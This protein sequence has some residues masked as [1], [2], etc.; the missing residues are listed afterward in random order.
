ML[1][2]QG[3][4]DE[5][6]NSPK[7]LT[8]HLLHASTGNY[9]NR[10]AITDYKSEVI[11]H[12]YN[13]LKE[14]AFRFQIAIDPLRFYRDAQLETPLSLTTGYLSASFQKF[15]T[16]ARSPERYKK[17]LQE[18]RLRS[19]QPCTSSQLGGCVQPTSMWSESLAF[20][21]SLVGDSPICHI[22]VDA[23][24]PVV[25]LRED[26]DLCRH[27]RFLAQLVIA[28]G[29][30]DR[31]D[32]SKS[33]GTGEEHVHFASAHDNLVRYEI[34]AN[35][36][37]LSPT[38]ETKSYIVFSGTCEENDQ[39]DQN[40]LGWE[41]TPQIAL[42]QADNTFQ[43]LAHNRCAWRNISP[44]PLCEWK[45]K[46]RKGK[47]RQG[48]LRNEA[49]SHMTPD[50]LRS[51]DATLKRGT[52]KPLPHL[53]RLKQFTT[54]F[55]IKLSKL[56]KSKFPF[57]VTYNFSEALLKFYF[58]DIRPPH[59][60][61]ALTCLENVT[62]G[63]TH[64]IHG[65]TAWWRRTSWFGLRTKDDALYGVQR[66]NSARGVLLAVNSGEVPILH[67]PPLFRPAEDEFAGNHQEMCC[68][69]RKA[70]T[71]GEGS[72][73]DKSC[74]VRDCLIESLASSK[75][76]T[77]D[78]YLTPF[79]LLR[80]ATRF[81]QGTGVEVGTH[82]RTCSQQFTC[83][84][85]PGFLSS[86]QNASSKFRMS[87]YKLFAHICVGIRPD[88]ATVKVIDTMPRE[89]R[90]IYEQPR[91]LRRKGSGKDGRECVTLPLP[92]LHAVIV[93][94]TSA[95]ETEMLFQGRHLPDT[96]FPPGISRAKSVWS[97]TGMQGQGKRVILTYESPWVAPPGIEPGSPWWKE[98]SLAT[99]PPQPL[100]GLSQA[101]AY[102]DRDMETYK[103]PVHT[104]TVCS[105]R[106]ERRPITTPYNPAIRKIV[107][108]VVVDNDRIVTKWK[109]SSL[110]VSRALSTTCDN[111]A[112]PFC[113][114][115]KNKVPSPP[116]GTTVVL[117]RDAA[118][119]NW[120]RLYCI[121]LNRSSHRVREQLRVQWGSR[122]E[123]KAQIKNVRCHS[124]DNTGKISCQCSWPGVES[125]TSRMRMRHTPL[126]K[127]DGGRGGDMWL[128]A[129]LV[130]K[131][132]SSPSFPSQ[133]WHNCGSVVGQASVKLTT[134]LCSSSPAQFQ[135]LSVPLT[136][137]DIQAGFDSGP[138]M[139][140]WSA[141]LKNGPERVP[142]EDVAVDL[143][144][145]GHLP[146]QLT[147]TET[148]DGLSVLASNKGTGLTDNTDVLNASKISYP[149]NGCSL[150]QGAS[151]MRS[152]MASSA[153]SSPHFDAALWAR[154]PA[155]AGR[156][157]G[158]S[159]QRG[160]EV[161][162]VHRGQ[163]GAALECKGTGKREIPRAE[164][165]A[166][167]GTIPAC[168]NL[169]ATSPGREPCSPRWDVGALAVTPPRP[170]CHVPDEAVGDV[171]PTHMHR[172]RRRGKVVQR[173]WLVHSRFSPQL[174]SSP[175][176]VILTPQA[177]KAYLSLENFIK[178]DNAPHSLPESRFVNCDQTASVTKN[179]TRL[180][181]RQH[182]VTITTPYTVLNACIFQLI[183][184]KRLFLR[185]TSP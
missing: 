177:N 109:I 74:A 36:Y 100:N 26:G 152:S 125:F 116:T 3:F 49:G 82:V 126:F 68:P 19:L 172:A 107:I 58:Q 119:L 77:R 35:N 114:N 159:Q 120:K 148:T 13:R 25:L 164:P 63:T 95:L 44:A 53:K 182:L 139:V 97:S 52:L 75:R 31:H 12:W 62:R 23:M 141:D 43:L 171:L 127:V 30:S 118:L 176:R 72:R 147:N 149:S 173:R 85:L 167:S 170:P 46:E 181:F 166:S 87:V 5:K 143:V 158:R 60:T 10:D 79:L 113:H 7:F 2:A 137:T 102:P 169:G 18:A 117:Q 83:T 155:K 42:W 98:S 163:Y 91:G 134:T 48:S 156:G 71:R 101:V 69:C 88:V 93:F 184:H 33:M 111:I 57:T 50:D 59:A 121:T 151:Q 110:A 129:Q 122:Q 132:E 80:L 73:T 150:A 112:Y 6:S 66:A 103:Y 175:S 65:R 55:S 21:C 4:D 70:W 39:E 29:T 130:V 178:G 8:F 45:G 27:V 90:L 157:L 106:C 183:H 145:Q 84:H 160:L 20:L 144:F 179:Y 161:T 61:R 1:A 154:L 47:E 16:S 165:T 124:P 128:C 15:H 115:S 146:L 56:H 185:C 94:A 9:V 153:F 34:S 67:P 81:V 105:E 108:E 99:T 28:R 138:G 136:R 135:M 64:R 123:R 133:R 92:I 17:R 14:K 51:A 76:W 54:N 168:E 142:C 162:R 131:R 40:L 37:N 174:F 41:D 86:V 96:C 11:D 38:D 22:D 104:S 140:V 180:K 89:R 78:G 32:M 24:A